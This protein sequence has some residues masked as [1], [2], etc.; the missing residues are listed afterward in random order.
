MSKISFLPSVSSPYNGRDTLETGDCMENALGLR[1]EH[2][3][4]FVP[5]PKFEDMGQ[6]MAGFEAKILLG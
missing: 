1:S 2:K 5:P 6:I 3:G 4:S